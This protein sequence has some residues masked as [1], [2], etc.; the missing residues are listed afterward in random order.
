M[1]PRVSIWGSR[2]E[3]IDNLPEL[4][5]ADAQH[6]LLNPAFDEMEHLEVLAR[7]VIPHV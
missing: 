1:V 6:M 3:C 4:V 2:A 5:R 7:E